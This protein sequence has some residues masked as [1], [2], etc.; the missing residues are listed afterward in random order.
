MPNY[1]VM[2]PL[3]AC[4]GLTLSAGALESV[5]SRGDHPAATRDL[6]VATASG[7]A[8]A[9]SR[10]HG[11]RPRTATRRVLALAPRDRLRTDLDILGV[12]IAS[13]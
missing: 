9:L 6:S 7:A 2:V 5:S 13:T 1:V 11:T 12:A 3:L 10:G 8:A 4:C